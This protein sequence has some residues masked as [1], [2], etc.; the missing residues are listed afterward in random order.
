MR[1][2]G[3][4]YLLG[5]IV[6]FLFAPQGM[7][8]KHSF[9]V[10]ASSLTDYSWRVCRVATGIVD[11]PGLVHDQMREGKEPRGCVAGIAG[12]KYPLYSLPHR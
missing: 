1:K 10:L 9:A 7:R 3:R 5:V 4:K 11:F 6:H 8:D 12:K 2:Q